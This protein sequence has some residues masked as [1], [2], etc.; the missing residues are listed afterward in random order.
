MPIKIHN[1]EYTTVPERIDQFREDH[2][3]WTLKAHIVERG[4]VILMKAVVKNAEGKTVGVGHAEEVRGSSKI[5]QT[6]ALENCETSAWGRALAACGY[7]GD[8]AASA[9]EV[10][11]AIIQQ[12]RLDAVSRVLAHNEAV[13]NHFESIMAIKQALA[14]EDF[15]LAAEA[16][17]EI[18]EEDRQALS[19]ATTK[20]GIYTLE[21]VKMFR[22]DRWSE[23]RK[24][25]IQQKIDS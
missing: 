9:E 25:Y 17:S 19:L 3:D 24:R 6:S 4:D 5:N 22:D 10:S 23:A 21:E 16:F 12:E 18:P 8:Q 7:G 1:K 14:D 13:R 15:D 20:G 11:Q 2:P